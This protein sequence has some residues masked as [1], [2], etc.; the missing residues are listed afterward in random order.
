MAPVTSF[1]PV[2]YVEVPQGV[3][4]LQAPVMTYAAPTYSPIIAQ[5]PV[6]NYALPTYVVQ[7]AAISREFGSDGQQFAPVE[8]PTYSLPAQLYY[9]TPRMNVSPQVFARLLRGE[10]LN[11]EEIEGSEQVFSQV[12][13][14]E[15]I[16]SIASTDIATVNVGVPP[17]ESKAKEKKTTSKKL[18]K[19]SRK[20]SRGW[21]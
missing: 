11:M 20:Q 5:A 17:T 4:H 15:S 16:R 6:M 21:C 2:T 1:T 7:N 12:P 10:Q 18:A 3:T 13:A 8:Y 19:V 9:D 14:L